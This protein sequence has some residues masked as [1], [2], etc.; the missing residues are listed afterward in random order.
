MIIKALLKNFPKGKLTLV[1]GRLSSA[2]QPSLH[3]HTVYFFRNGVFVL[4]RCSEILTSIPICSIDNSHLC[5]VMAQEGIIFVPDS[6]KDFY[7]I[8]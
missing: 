5:H 2:K 1:G 6:K 3:V 8:R 4:E 7:D